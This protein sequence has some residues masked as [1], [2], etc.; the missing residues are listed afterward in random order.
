MSG[1]LERE[2]RLKN[3]QVVPAKI[4]ENWRV[5]ADFSTCDARVQT[6]TFSILFADYSLRWPQLPLSA[7]CVKSDTI[8]P[9]RSIRPV[10]RMQPSLEGIVR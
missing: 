8:R 3:A 4:D 6:V 5:F 10:C 9:G 7:T 1:V 2:R